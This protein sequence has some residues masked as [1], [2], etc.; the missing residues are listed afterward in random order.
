VTI[1]LVRHGETEWNRERRHQG[2][3]DSPLTACGIAQAR[4]IGRRLARLPEA[5]VAPIIASPQGRARH[6]AEI[7]HQ[8][9][10]GSPAPRFDARL[11]EHSVGTW[12]G[13]TYDEIET[14][15]P[16]VFDGDGDHQWYFRGPG[17]E[18]YA[19]FAK[20]VGQWLEEQGEALPVIVVAH[21]LVS[22]VM[23]GLYAGLPPAAALSLPVPQDRI[24]RLTGGRIETI[25]VKS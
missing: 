15:A 6:T 9:L 12:D 16:G 8:E 25:A 14:R 2:H 3:F 18:S 20:R 4:A 17:S 19:A 10:A 11:R 7:I 24:F 21:G 5:L 22:R 1:L 23:R 13:L